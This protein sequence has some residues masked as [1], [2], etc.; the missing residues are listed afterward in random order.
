MSRIYIY[1]YIEKVGFQA[2]DPTTDFRG[3]GLLAL[4][5]LE[6]P[7]NYIDELGI[8]AMREKNYLSKFIQLL[9]KKRIGSSLLWLAFM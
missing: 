5:N 6:Y 2:E 1:I 4:Y 8:Y 9:P 7:L 3:A